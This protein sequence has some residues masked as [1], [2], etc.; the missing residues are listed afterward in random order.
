MYLSMEDE[1]RLRKLYKDKKGIAEGIS[2]L[3]HVEDTDENALLAREAWGMVAGIREA[4]N[5]LGIT[6]DFIEAQ[7]KG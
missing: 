6:V 3:T 2:L 7:K 1:A 5:V 4:G